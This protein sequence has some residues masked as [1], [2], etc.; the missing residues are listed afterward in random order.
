MLQMI[1]PP[2][3]VLPRSFRGVFVTVTIY[4][5]HVGNA[6]LIKKVYFTLSIHSSVARA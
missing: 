2:I 3:S 1:P 6:N 4:Q 5:Q